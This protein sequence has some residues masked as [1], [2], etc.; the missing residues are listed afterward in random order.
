MS[1]SR[2][3]EDGESLLVLMPSE[4]DGMLQQLQQKKI[5]IEKIE[6]NQKRQFDVQKKLESFCAQNVEL[7][8]SAKRCF[9][10]YVKSVSLL[11]NKQIFD[12][13]KLET[14]AYAFSLGLAAPPRIRFLQKLEKV[15]YQKLCHHAAP[16]KLATSVENDVADSDESSQS[17]EPVMLPFA[18]KGRILVDDSNSD[19]EDEELFK[20]KKWEKPIPDDESQDL[21]EKQHTKVLTKAAIAKKIK[22]KKLVVNTK[23][24]FDDEGQPQDTRQRRKHIEDDSEC[25]TGINIDIAKKIMA[26][27]DKIDKQ[28]F[29][30]KIKDKHKEKRLKEKK[31]RKKKTKDQQDSAAIC[32][33]GSSDSEGPDISW[34]PDPDLIADYQEKGESSTRGRLE[35]DS[36][37][38]TNESPNPVRKKR[39]HRHSSA[40]DTEEAHT[41][42]P[43]DMDEELALKL[44]KT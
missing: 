8:E 22:K 4:E 3:E 32:D 27:E 7:K 24:T 25:I 11:K 28:L 30:E 9:V 38:E 14:D 44:L 16:K 37:S 39:K 18:N 10:S 1:I 17:N 36:H 23:V 33:V 15:R 31:N 6:V 5:P 12:V 19:R 41:S 34:L 21:F 35:Q 26:E 2:Y 13:S 43:L 40:E 29:R 20:V 42:L